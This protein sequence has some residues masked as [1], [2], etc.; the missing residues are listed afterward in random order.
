MDN[1]FG[2]A[3]AFQYRG[4]GATGRC[5]DVGALGEAPADRYEDRS[6]PIK[7]A[8]GEVK[9]SLNLRLGGELVLKQLTSFHRFGNSRGEF[10]GNDWFHQVIDNALLK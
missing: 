4:T 6:Q 5:L 2:T 8:E 10:V 3:V 9:A 7:K 1:L